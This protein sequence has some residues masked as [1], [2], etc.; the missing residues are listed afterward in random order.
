MRRHPHA[1]GEEQLLLLY[2]DILS[3]LKIAELYDER[4]I[5][6]VECKG[7]EV[8]LRLFCLDPSDLLD[9]AMKRGKAAVLFSATLTPLEYFTCVLG[10]GS[11]A[12]RLMLSSPFPRENLCLL[13]SDRISTKY[14]DRQDSLEPVADQIALTVGSRIGNYLVYFP[15]YAYLRE[16]YEVFQE[17][18]PNVSTLVQHSGMEEE[19]REAFLQ[20]FRAEPTQTLVG[21]CVLG[22]IYAEGIDLQGE[23]LIG[24]VIVGVGLP[25]ISRE[26]DFIREYY[27]RQNG[28]G[29]EYAYRYPGMNKVLQ[30]A[31]RVI[32]DET[33]R[34]VVVLIDQRFTSSAYRE[35]FPDHWRHYA[36][37]HDNQCLA[38][39]L[40][41][42]WGKT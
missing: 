21:F 24:T 31:G 42:F 9:K 29:F 19:E 5:T 1:P 13:V 22:G 30:A 20:R 38:E 11:D 34:G 16:V 41:Q 39:R 8:Y 3:F 37:V 10:G 6:W 40:R 2:F 35:L 32:R 25:Q 12:K 14:K 7:G 15:S 33:D 27:D 18:Y 26:Q 17:R 23:R 28:R 4:Y 36:T